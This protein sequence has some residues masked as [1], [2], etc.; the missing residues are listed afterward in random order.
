MRASISHAPVTRHEAEVIVAPVQVAQDEVVSTP[1]A[2]SS[3]LDAP[4]VSQRSRS[5]VLVLVLVAGAIV[6]TCG[7]Y[8]LIFREPRQSGR[9]TGVSQPVSV[10]QPGSPAAVTSPVFG[11]AEAQTAT[12]VAAAIATTEA[13]ETMFAQI[14]AAA[15]ATAKAVGSGQ[16][17]ATATARAL[18]TWNA[19]ATASALAVEAVPAQPYWEP[20]LHDAFDRDENRWSTGDYSSERLTGNRYIIDGVYRW[21]ADAKEGFRWWSNAQGGSMTDFHLMVEARFV[22]GSDGANCGVVFRRQKGGDYYLFRVRDD[23]KYQVSL[24]S[25]GEA[26]SLVRWTGAPTFS[27]GDFNYLEVTGEGSHFTFYVNQEQ[28]AEVD[29]DTL[30]DGSVALVVGLPQAGD[31]GIFEFDDFELY[32]PPQE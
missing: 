19:A 29:D 14:D 3:A 23:G 12:V 2:P 7:S 31:A 11:A 28:V 17:A 27:S 32:V 16:T 13:R 8:W 21:Q 15:T 9:T 6:I 24:M 25:G 5:L 30:R 10:V 26:T 18:A 22:W 1:S 20:A 4:A